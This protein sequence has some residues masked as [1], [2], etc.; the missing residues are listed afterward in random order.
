MPA[1]APRPGGLVIMPGAR[2]PMHTLGDAWGFPEYPP[3]RGGGS[4][5]WGPA[6]EETGGAG[7][8]GRGSSGM[9]DPA[10]ELT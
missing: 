10:A 9:M 7:L 1:S 5:S 8:P 3:A 6:G 4:E 2:S